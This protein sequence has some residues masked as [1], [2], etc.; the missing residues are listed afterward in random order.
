MTLFNVRS[1]FATGGATYNPFESP[2]VPLSSVALDGMFGGVS[3]EA[4]PSVTEDSALTIPTVFRCVSLI[5]SLIAGCPLITYRNPGK[6]PVTVPAL[7]PLNSNTT[8]TQY[9]LWELVLIHL[10]LCGNAYVL[11]IR[12]GADRIVDLR[13]IWP[14]R[15]T[16]K[17]APGGGK[18]FEVKRVDA[19][20]R[21]LPG[22]PI[23]YTPDELMHIPGMGYDGLSGLSPIGYAKQAIGTALAGDRLAARFYSNGTQLSGILKTAV[24]LTSETQ[25][26]EMKRKW[27][28]KN[29]GVGNAGGVAVLDAETEF[30][31][32]T[33]NPDEL[34]F[35][36]SRRWQT[37]ELARLYGIPPH[38]VGDVERSTSWGTGIEQQNTAF[39]A[40]TLAS[41]ANRIEQRVTREVVSTRGQTAAFDFSSLLRGD[42]T[43][44]FNAYAIAVQWGF[45]TRQEARLREDWE[46]ID[47][48]DEPLQPLNMQAG[49]TGTEKL[50][51]NVVPLG[52]G[53]APGSGKNQAL[54]EAKNGK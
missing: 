9:E 36:E 24:P 46:P 47:G 37:N 30:Q 7:D 10:L 12:D 29:S 14:R 43:E 13:P 38:L 32:L 23:T 34:Q 41:W 35:L 8:Y 2:A 5:S 44:R 45:M 51:P 28:I 50:D 15:V 27:A 11:K 20:G 40:Y 3:S 6:K 16:P 19:D 1:Q 52:P 54:D 18:V 17:P 42:M 49:S 26:D 31:P 21:L 22:E 53:K 33:I 48:L 39:V 25:A 4:G